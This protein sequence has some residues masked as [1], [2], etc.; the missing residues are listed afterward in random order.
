MRFYQDTSGHLYQF[1]N[2][3][4]QKHKAKILRITKV[5]AKEEKAVIVDIPS[6]KKGGKK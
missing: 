2:G 6:K 4:I 1:K 5:K 3:K